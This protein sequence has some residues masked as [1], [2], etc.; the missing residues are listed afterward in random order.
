MTEIRKK[1]FSLQAGAWE[2]VILI[3]ALL[4]FWFWTDTSGHLNT[5]VFPSP[6][7][8][9]TTLVH[10][11]SD[12]SLLLAIRISVVRVL[13]GYGIAMAAG[14]SCGILMGLS[15][16]MYHIVNLLLQ[17]IRPIPPI[18]WIPLVILWMG[19][20]ESSKVFLIFLGGFFNVLLNVISGIRYTDQKLVE[21]AYVM[22][23]PRRKYI[24]R[25]VIPAALP[26]I[27]TGL[28]ISLGSCWTC[29]V[30]AELVASTSGVGYMIS[31][32]RNFGQ[33]DV[34]VIG[35]LSIGIIGKIMDSLL[36]FLEKKVLA[37]NFQGGAE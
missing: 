4:V 34:V 36:A 26:N 28:R 17:I 3:I 8:V 1:H 6:L 23:T 33:M 35:M 2:G 7:E 25:L 18:A 30:A 24:T 37:W 32:A 29:V 9:W 15:N 20:G 13:K 12:G 16:H 5:V 14:I 10:K 27:F 21:V 22:E 11:L 31:N 19:I